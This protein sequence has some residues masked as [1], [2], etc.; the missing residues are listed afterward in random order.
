MSSIST[1]VIIPR[2]SEYQASVKYFI[3]RFAKIQRGESVQWTNLDSVPYRIQGG[4]RRRFTTLEVLPGEVEATEFPY[5]MVD[6]IDYCCDI[7][8]HGNELGCVIIFSKNEEAMTNTERLR[9][10]SKAFNIN[11]PDVL[12][13]LRG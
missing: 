2:F 1:N 13:H 8:T 3:P 7:P 5:E 6:R 10:L 12:A 9:F 4:R 11:P